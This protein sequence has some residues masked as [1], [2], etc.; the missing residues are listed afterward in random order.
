MISN[1]Y[2]IAQALSWGAMPSMTKVELE[3]V[4]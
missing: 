2:L 1:H 4:L 3:F